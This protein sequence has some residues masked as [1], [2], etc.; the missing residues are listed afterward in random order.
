MKDVI[1]FAS[2]GLNNRGYGQTQLLMEVPGVEIVALCDVYEDLCDRSADAVEKY[3]GKRPKI[4]TD[5]RRMLEDGGFDAVLCCTTWITHAQIAV[6][7]MRAGFDVAFEVGGFSDV[8]EGWQLVRTAEETGRI[9]MML[10]NC[11]YCRNELAIFN[12]AKKGMFGEIVHCTG[13]YCH[14][15]R[16]EI[17]YGREIRHGRL[18]NFIHRNAEL[19][20]THQFG[21][22]SKLIGL[23][24]GNRVLT[25]SS[26]ASKARGLSSYL[27]RTKGLDYLKDEEFREGDVVDTLMTCANGETIHLIHEC[28]MPRPYSRK[29]S[30]AGTNGAFED[31]PFGPAIYFDKATGEF[32]W[33]YPD[34][35]WERLEDY[36]DEYE[37]PLWHQYRDDGV[38]EGHDGVDWL[39][40][41]A[42]VESVKL[43]V[44]P[45]IDVYD[46]ALWG[47]ITALS[48]QSAAMGGATLPVPDFTR[49]KWIDRE[50]FRRGIYCLEEVCTDCF[51]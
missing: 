29:Y 15:L 20:P 4:Y 46:S 10:E 5:Y 24:R 28:S 36:M 13:G 18:K 51:E 43:G 26:F 49:G 32:D 25:L 30:V 2:V 19:Y 7:S 37:H 22:I 6:D 34:H 31:G 39:V 9:C 3:S 41:N 40:L 38:K 17:L 50:P 1:R 42:F 12:M 8:E 16:D 48:E 35:D 14:D 33:S 47:S 11:C 44:Q 45:P 21:P 27:P 23:N